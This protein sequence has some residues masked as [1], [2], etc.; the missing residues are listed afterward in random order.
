[1]AVHKINQRNLPLILVG[2]GL[3][4]V[5]GLSGK[6]KSYAER[7]FDFPEV[8]PL[9]DPDAHRALQSPVRSHAVNFTEEAIADVIRETKGYPYFLQQWGHEAWNIAEKSPIT[10]EDIQRASKLAISNLDKS[11]FRVCFD[12]LTPREREYLR[13]LALLGPGSQRSGDVAAALGVKSQSI[14]PVRSSLIK[15]GMIYSRNMAILLSR[16]RYLTNPC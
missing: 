13:E 7:L 5:I 11:F 8:G 14:A 1:M 15:K 16:S 6:S 9:I 2:A 12:R 3:P 4:Q 10:V